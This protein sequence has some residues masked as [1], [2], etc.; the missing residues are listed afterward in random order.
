MWK[1]LGKCTLI[2]GLSLGLGRVESPANCPKVV[3][4]ALI[5]KDLEVR[6]SCLHGTGIIRTCM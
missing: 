1:K 3:V 2:A 4:R 5:G 6:P